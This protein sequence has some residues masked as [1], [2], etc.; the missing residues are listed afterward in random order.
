MFGDI[1]WFFCVQLVAKTC[2]IVDS[3]IQCRSIEETHKEVG[4]YKTLGIMLVPAL[5]L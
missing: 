5:Y 4:Y 1:L 3:F 2:Q